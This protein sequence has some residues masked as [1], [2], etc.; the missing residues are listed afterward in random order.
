MA[1]IVLKNKPLE[2][3]LRAAYKGYKKEKYKKEQLGFLLGHKRSRETFEILKAIS[4]RGGIKT[5]TGVDFYP[6][7]FAR[8]ALE[9]AQEHGLTWLGRFH[10]HHEIA[11]RAYHGLSRAD[12]ESFRVMAREIPSLRVELTV[13]V[14]AENGFWTGAQNLSKTLF[15]SNC[16]ETYRYLVKGYTF[17]GFGQVSVKAPNLG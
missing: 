7:D 9:L 5:R 10:T 13:N 6:A 12:K 2:T 14:Y 15:I 1:T 11:G 4:Y 16:D 3:V 17:P 8:R